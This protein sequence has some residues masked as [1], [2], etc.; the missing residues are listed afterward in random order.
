V[1]RGTSDKDLALTSDK[2]LALDVRNAGPAAQADT[3]AH[4]RLYGQV[5]PPRTADDGFLAWQ[6]VQVERTRRLR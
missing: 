2:D 3:S 5:D 4:R 1:R 6:P